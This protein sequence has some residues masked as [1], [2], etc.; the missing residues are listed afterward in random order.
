[1]MSSILKLLQIRGHK[2]LISK[3]VCSQQI[4]DLGQPSP[5]LLT[6]LHLCIMPIIQPAEVLHLPPTTS[7]HKEKTPKK[8]SFSIFRNVER[9]RPEGP[10]GQYDFSID[11]CCF[12]NVRRFLRQLI[13][14]KRR[15]RGPNDRGSNAGYIEGFFVRKLEGIF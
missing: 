1:M 11:F 4:L 10:R 15:D 7:T 5:S 9:S 2:Y 8:V 14:D 13:F 3:D 6:N 12:G